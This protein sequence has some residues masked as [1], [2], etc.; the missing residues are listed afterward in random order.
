M[1]ASIAQ[2][3]F[4]EHIIPTVREWE[5]SPLEPHRAMN[6]AVNLNQ[7]ADHFF[8][9]FQADSVKVLGASNVKEFRDALAASTPEFG[10]INDVA[11]AHKHFKLN[12]SNRKITYASQTTTGSMGWGEAAYGEG[13]WGSP[14]EIVVV[15]DDGQKHHLS[16]AVKKI[17]DMWKCR[18]P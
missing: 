4:D 15:F 5:E 13:Q 10:L 1:A 7:M 9:E 16:T 18:L 6:A 3:F 14:P 12:R 11:D 2:L 17:T 8:Y